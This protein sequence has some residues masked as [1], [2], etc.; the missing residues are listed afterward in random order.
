MPTTNHFA[1]L[2]TTGGPVS[3][4]NTNLLRTSDFITGAFPAEYGNANAAVFDVKFRNGNTAKHEF[5]GQ[6]SAFSGAE[7]MA[8]GPLNK[9]KQ[10]SYLVSY[11]YGIASV[12]A[13]G[14]S[15]VPFYQDLSFKLNFGESKFGR[16]ELF[17]MG[18][19]SSIDFIGA[20]IDET[21]LFADPTVDAFV[22]NGIG[23][24]G[25][26]HVY[27]FSPTA[28]L[29][30]M[31]GSTVM[32]SNFDQDNFVE[33]TEGNEPVSYRATEALDRESRY[34]ISTQFN[35]KV[36]AR[37]NYRVG[38]INE[39]FRLENDVRDRDNRVD[40]P[41]ANGDGIPDYFVTVRD[42]DQLTPLAQVY[43]QGEYKFSDNLSLTA[44]LH[45]QYF[46]LTDDF[47]IGPRAALSWQFR[48]NQ[49]LSVAYGLHS[50][51]VPLPILLLSE[52]TA[53]GQFEATNKSLSFMKS[54]QFVV[55][56]DRKFG[57]DWRVKLEG[58]Y[59]SLFDIPVEQFSSSYSAINEGGDFVFEE[60]GSLVSSGTGF[61]YGAEITIEKFFSRNFYALITTSLFESRYEGSD[62]IERNTSF[63]NNY[64]VNALVGKEWPVGAQ[65]KNA[66]IFDTRFSA[67]GGRPYTPIDLDGTRAN[68]GNTVLF[69]DQA[70][71]ERYPVYMRWDVKA[72]FRLNST[73]GKVSHLI[74]LDFQNVTNR[75]NIFVRRYN[76]VTD[77][78]NDVNQIGFFP[79]FMYRIQF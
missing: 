43:G 26:T 72:G 28:Y 77:Q 30:T 49:R 25:L 73:K 66:I 46:E 54:N 36:N 48:P 57:P 74:F 34:T 64:V 61:N 42:I 1:T 37:L 12:A 19:L 71:S 59:Q 50:Q 45:S 55:G 69:E 15:A 47:Q 31:V 21:D 22:S 13:T 60:K 14:T 44:G 75:E 32:E 11:R 51:M 8:E 53:P 65:K 10:S 29:K 4:L 79:D 24:I 56:Y 78:I 70:F 7:L 9:E 17:G 23:A 5:T 18:G 39:M 38:V 63:N 52:E 62:G 27:R 16:F 3:A 76:P 2:G 33:A 58:Y 41:D 67:S 35:K 68:G 6:V 20:E 40:I